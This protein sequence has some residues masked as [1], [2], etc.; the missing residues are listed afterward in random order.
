M[1]IEKAFK[2]QE[3]K[4]KIPK[5]VLFLLLMLGFEIIGFSCVKQKQ[6]VN[7]ESDV[8]TQKIVCAPDEYQRRILMG[9]NTQ[10]LFCFREISIRL[11]EK[12]TFWMDRN[13]GALKVALEPKDISLE[14]VGFFYQWKNL[15]LN[16]FAWSSLTLNISFVIPVIL[17]H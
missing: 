10:G 5:P 14:T 6:Q 15:Y 3:K 8:L 2:I 11:G 12:T 1:N 9:E 16:I 4:R 13:L 17:D 7:H